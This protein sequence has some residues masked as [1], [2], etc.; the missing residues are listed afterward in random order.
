MWGGKS[1]IFKK[2]NTKQGKIHVHLLS[3]DQGGMSADSDDA[4]ARAMQVIFAILLLLCW[5]SLPVPVTACGVLKALR[6]R[7][8]RG[9][10][11]GLCADANHEGRSQAT[12]GGA[13]AK[14]R[15][16]GRL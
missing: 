13:A 5:V 6:L 8:C 11:R 4:E 15:A 16:A 3:S 7:T 12:A 1:P 9:R 14:G 2:K 10:G